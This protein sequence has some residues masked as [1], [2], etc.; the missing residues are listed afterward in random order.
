M[1]PFVP[2]VMLLAA[3]PA[4]AST[5]DL[6]VDW[7]DKVAPTV[8]T[9]AQAG[10]PVDVLLQVGTPPDLA[11]A[12]TI[13]DRVERIRWV[14]GTLRDAALRSQRPVVG[15]LRALGVDYDAYWVASLVRAR[16]DGDRLADV[17]ALDA[18]RRVVANPVVATP[19]PAPTADGGPARAVEWNVSQVGADALWALGITGE[20]AVIGAQ[21]T[22][23]DWDHPALQH[24][25]RGWDGQTATHDHNWHDAIHSG[26]GSCGADAAEPC[27]DY[28]HG[29]HTLG[30]MVGDDGGSN[31]IGLAPGAR[32]IGCRNMD[33]GNGTPATYTE[34]FQWFLA[35]T[36]AA[37]GDPD[38]ALAPHVINNSWA[39]PPSEGCDA[40]TLAQV[41]ANVRAAGIVVVASAGNSGSTCGSVADPPAIYDDSFSV[42]AVDASDVVAG[43]S[44]RGPVS[45]DGS[46]RMKPDIVAPGVAVRS[47]WRGGGYAT[48]QGTSMAGPHVAAAVA[49]LLD[50]R[51]DLAGRPD[52]IEALLVAAAAPLTT[53]EGCGG[54]STAAVPNNTYGGG[55]LDLPALIAGDADGDGV[56]LLD[57]CAPLDP[58]LWSPPGEVASLEL[59][60]L[61]GVARLSWAPP[62]DPGTAAPSYRV[63]RST[64][65]TLAGATCAAAGLT[66]TTWDDPAPPPAPGSVEFLAVRVE[67]A[68]AAA[69]G[70]PGTCP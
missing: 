28:G 23:Y 70:Q 44:S 35:P 22:G 29:T 41:V 37:G 13:R 32:W 67:D 53:V 42:G 62:G 20:G 18:V 38:P 17:A 2:I 34:C 8:L 31:R 11:H 65:P 15:R 61:A 51:P 19:L 46:E 48:A 7:R 5:R 39:C 49:L 4:A 57:D 43:F 30:T 45:I 59:D 27:D 64:D 52:D 40:D 21:D 58:A 9:R 16:L 47:S 66:G 50:A 25:Y 24:A 10:E 54:D 6:P 69:V 68:C 63:V 12:A 36:D 14:V 55:R 3:C 26:G 1:R 56:S 60:L 33:V